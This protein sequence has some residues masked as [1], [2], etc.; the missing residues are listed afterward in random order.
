MKRILGKTLPIEIP[1]RISRWR[2]RIVHPVPDRPPN[3][4]FNRVAGF[5]ILSVC[6]VAVSDALIRLTG[7]TAPGANDCA[8]ASVTATGFDGRIVVDPP[9]YASSAEADSSAAEVATGRANAGAGAQPERI[10]EVHRIVAHIGIHVHP[11]PI[12]DRI[13]LHEPAEGRDCRCGPC[14]NRGRARAA[15]PG[16]YIGT[17]RCCPSAGR[18]VFVVAVD[19]GHRARAVGDRDDRAALVGVEAAAVA[20]AGALVPDQRLV[21]ARAVDV[22]AQ[23]GVAELSYSTDQ[24]LRR[25]SRTSDQP[26]AAAV[27]LGRAAERVVGK[28]VRP[29]APV[30]RFSAV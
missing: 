1:A 30:S 12:A 18:A 25:H 29:G 24:A 28:G 13:G 9:S 14:S 20:G 11:G 8:R 4:N 5:V 21:D 15:R 10:G 7:P 17:G 6:S 23:R 27:D 22:A 26:A 2:V 3:S 16:R 19:A